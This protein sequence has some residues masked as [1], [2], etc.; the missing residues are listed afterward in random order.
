[1]TP[2]LSL[3]EQITASERKI[4]QR[5][6][7]AKRLAARLK[8]RTIEKITSPGALVVA[9]GFGV[10]LEQTS[11]NRWGS[12]IHLLNA[13]TSGGSLVLALLS[14]VDSGDRPVH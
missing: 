1:M 11:H 4:I 9:G 2:I 6:R 5:R 10:V 3:R 14:R 7:H 12:L 13:I 8:C